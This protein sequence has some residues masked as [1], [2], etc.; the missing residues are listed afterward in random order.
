MVVFTLVGMM[1]LL[2]IGTV[3]PA[4]TYKR[5]VY[6]D[7]TTLADIREGL[8]LLRNVA[9]GSKVGLILK[10]IDFEPNI[11]FILNLQSLQVQ[12]LN[13]E[14]SGVLFAVCLLRNYTWSRN[15][16]SQASY[17]A[18]IAVKNAVINNSCSWVGINGLKKFALVNLL[19]T[20]SALVTRQPINFM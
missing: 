11:H 7:K 1:V 12:N 17:D 13:N 5:E 20:F 2:S 14:T 8:V 19:S 3:V 4:S 18:L 15:N 9:N 6:E 16:I 10:Q